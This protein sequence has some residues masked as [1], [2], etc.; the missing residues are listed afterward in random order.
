MLKSVV[1]SI[2]QRNRQSSIATITQ[3]FQPASGS[4]PSTMIVWREVRK[5]CFHA[6]Q[7]PVSH[8]SHRQMPNAASRGVRSVETGPQNSGKQLSEVINHG[9]QCGDPMVGCKCWRMYGE[10]HLPACMMPTVKFSSGGVT[11]WSCFS[12]G[13]L[14]PWLLYVAM[15]RP[16]LGST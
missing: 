14:A 2:V 1:F 10:R 8:T 6:E 4:T 5:L 7:L 9:I 13:G 11:V 16:V 3:D 15:S 12:W